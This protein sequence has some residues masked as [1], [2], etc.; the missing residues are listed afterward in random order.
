MWD[1]TRQ[2]LI[3]TIKIQRNTKKHLLIFYNEGREDHFIQ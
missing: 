1:K 2:E 3:E